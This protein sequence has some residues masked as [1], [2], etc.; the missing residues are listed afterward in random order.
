V[1]TGVRFIRVVVIYFS[2]QTIEGYVSAPL[3]QRGAVNIL[4]A[5]TLF[6]IV[7]FGATFGVM[8]V[9][10]AAPLLAVGRAA[11]QRLYVDDW[12]QDRQ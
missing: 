2:I 1:T 5:C 8:G 6:A 12:L 9:A 4:P 3:I 10:L 11:V 7:V